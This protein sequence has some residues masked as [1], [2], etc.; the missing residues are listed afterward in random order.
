MI[1]LAS[2]KYHPHYEIHEFY[3]DGYLFNVNPSDNVYRKTKID[4][5]LGKK[6]HSYIPC[7]MFD[8]ELPE[9][10]NFV[11]YNNFEERI[12]M[13]SKI[14]EEKIFENI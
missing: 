2:R 5:N 3:H 4:V 12:D 10:L 6:P 9:T 14:I 11:E 8:Y 1:Y 13:L 7:S